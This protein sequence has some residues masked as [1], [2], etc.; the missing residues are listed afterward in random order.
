MVVLTALALSAGAALAERLSLEV[1]SDYLNGIQEAEAE[2]VQMNDDG[3]TASGIV[4]IKRPGKMRFDYA[5]PE[6][7]L[8]LASAGAVY[9]VDRKLGGQTQTYPLSRTP[10]S[11]VL[12]REVDLSAPGVVIDHAFDGAG[13][14]V[15]AQ[16]PRNPDSGRLTLYFEHD[17][18]RLARWVVET[19]DG[20]TTEVA[21]G[22]FRPVP[23]PLSLFLVENA[24]D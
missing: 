12:A 14:V 3:S 15:T 20:F 2:F 9:V 1:L 22:P 10:L 11:I 17:P 18:V 7:A 5:P 8:V 4:A 21:L 6:A 19:P 24:T 13:T 23:L 16:D